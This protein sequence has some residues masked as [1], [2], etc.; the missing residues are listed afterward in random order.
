MSCSVAPMPFVL[1]SFL[2]LK[3]YSEKAPGPP[4]R[5]AK[6]SDYSEDHVSRGHL[7]PGIKEN[8][9]ITGWTRPGHDGVE[10]GQL[11]RRS[12]RPW[13]LDKLCRVRMSSRLR[14]LLFRHRAELDLFLV[15]SKSII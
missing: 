10:I 8:P 7:N 3:M 15:F 12:I 1:R 11:H 5:S 9:Y 2:L 6:S 14:E 4:H 13:M